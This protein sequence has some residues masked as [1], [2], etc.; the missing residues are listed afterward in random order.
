[1][2]GGAESQDSWV[3]CLTLPFQSPPRASVSPVQWADPCPVGCK[4]PQ[5][6]WAWS[7]LKVSLLLKGE[8]LGVGWGESSAGSLRRGEGPAGAP[9]PT[10]TLFSL[11]SETVVCATRATVMLYDDANKKWVTAGSGPQAVS[12]VQIYHSPGSNTFRVVGRKMQADQQVV[13]NCAIVKGM[14]YNQAT[15]NFHQW[16]DARQVWGLNFGSK[17]DAS[18][19]ASGM[20]LA[21]DRLEAGE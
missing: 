20:L 18:Q 15:P 2:E 5:S 16:R 3:L 19:F 9:P 6:I 7:A 12:W 1:M 17:E 8:L 10:F 14:K 4:A 13:I 21:L 11:R